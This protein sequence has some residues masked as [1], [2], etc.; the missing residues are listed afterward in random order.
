MMQEK[1]DLDLDP[2]GDDDDVEL[3]AKEFGQFE[4][5]F[6][7]LLSPPYNQVLTLSLHIKPSLSSRTNYPDK[8]EQL[9]SNLP[10]LTH[11]SINC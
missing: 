3:S 7:I 10:L 1:D 9:R 4:I 2:E 8:I 11:V 6:A 5:F